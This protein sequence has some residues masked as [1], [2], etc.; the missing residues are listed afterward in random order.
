MYFGPIY[1]LRG[2]I[3]A[4]HSR[5]ALCYRNTVANFAYMT[6]KANLDEL[7]RVCSGLIGKQTM[8]NLLTERQKINDRIRKRVYLYLEEKYPDENKSLQIFKKEIINKYYAHG[9][10]MQP[11]NIGIRHE[12]GKR[13]IELSM[14]DSGEYREQMLERS[15]NTY[16]ITLHSIFLIICSAIENKNNCN[17][18]EYR[19]KIEEIQA[20]LKEHIPYKQKDR[21]E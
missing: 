5:D 7:K 14:F 11:P 8:T 15:L 16:S 10:A 4:C 9:V 18:D 19:K 1:A 13:M 17:M 3:R 6:E 20:Q 12:E 2:N 21:A